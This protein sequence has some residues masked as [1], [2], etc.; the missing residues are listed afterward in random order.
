MYTVYTFSE[1]QHFSNFA[2]IFLTAPFGN[3]NTY[4]GL[5][6]LFFN[7]SIN[8]CQQFSKLSKTYL[9]LEYF[10]YSCFWEYKHISKLANTFLTTPSANANTLTAPSANANIFLSLPIAPAGK[11]FPSPSSCQTF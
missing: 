10:F 9:L 1:C 8:K 7:S 11:K 5:P 3:V 2:N 6:T 4:L